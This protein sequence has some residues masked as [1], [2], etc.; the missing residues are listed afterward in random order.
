MITDNSA[1]PVPV[2]LDEETRAT[3]ALLDNPYVT[4]SDKSHVKFDLP[5][6]Q[7]FL[8]A[9]AEGATVTRA[10]DIVG[11]CRRTPS[12]HRRIDEQ[13]AA[14]WAEAERRQLDGVEEALYRLGTESKNVAALIFWLKNNRPDKWRDRH[15]LNVERNASVNVQ[16]SEEG[17]TGILDR[18][19]RMRLEKEKELSAVDEAVVAEESG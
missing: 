17:A 11:V 6:K 7:A 19:A 16:I 13:F 14:A 9:I 2:D 3:L 1:L 12:N 18:L 4:D 15:D 8:L 10:A 5:R